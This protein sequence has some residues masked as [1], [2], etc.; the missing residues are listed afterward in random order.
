MLYNLVGI[1]MVLNAQGSY[2]KIEEALEVL[3]EASIRDPQNPQVTFDVFCV[4]DVDVIVCC[5]FLLVEVPAC[6]YLIQS[7]SSSGSIR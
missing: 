2:G 7:G 5:L 4:N 3:N 1:G 6:S